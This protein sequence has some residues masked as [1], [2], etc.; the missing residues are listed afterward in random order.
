[1]VPLPEALG[2]PAEALATQDEEDEEELAAI[3]CT[4]WVK[5]SVVKER[6]ALL[7]DDAAAVLTAATG[8]G[9]VVLVQVV[10]STMRETV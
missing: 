4:V 9:V 10:V 8:A 2:M 7:D 3:R 1:M 5:I 6:G